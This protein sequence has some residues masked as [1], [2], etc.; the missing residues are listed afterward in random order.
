MDK[1]GHDVTACLDETELEKERELKEAIKK[2]AKELEDI[3]IKIKK[4]R[5]APEEAPHSSR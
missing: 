1:Q 4:L 3:D 5:K 2:K